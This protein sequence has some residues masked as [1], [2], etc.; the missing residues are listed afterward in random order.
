[1]GGPI[2]SFGRRNPPPKN[3]Q[4]QGTIDQMVISEPSSPSL[5]SCRDRKKR[6]VRTRQQ[7]FEVLVSGTFGRLAGIMV[8]VFSQSQPCESMCSRSSRQQADGLQGSAEQQ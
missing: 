3:M 7:S 8:D 6:A 1:V 2:E 5:V 4:N